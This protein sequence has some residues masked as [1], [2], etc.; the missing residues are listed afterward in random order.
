MFAFNL[1]MTKNEYKTYLPC[2]HFLTHRRTCQMNIVIYS[3]C[4]FITLTLTYTKESG[5]G[6]RFSK[7][8]L[9][10]AF[11]GRDFAIFNTFRTGPVK[12]DTPAYDIF[13]MTP[14]PQI[15]GVLFWTVANEDGTGDDYCH[16]HLLPSPYHCHIFIIFKFTSSSG[17][18][19]FSV[20]GR[21][22]S[23]RVFL[24]CQWLLHGLAGQ[25]ICNYLHN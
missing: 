22:S 23:S 6:L 17:D 16:I 25:Y 4:T 15:F 19:A 18:V 3:S 8:S 5:I 9:T 20:S 10:F 1:L 12:K 14:L 2:L 13:I 24:G 21:S 7:K 11:F